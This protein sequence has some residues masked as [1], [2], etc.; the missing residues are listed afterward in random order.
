MLLKLLVIFHTLGATIW[1]G[2][3]LILAITIVPQALKNR[4]LEP[5]R[6]FEEH[7][8]NLGLLALLVQVLSTIKNKL[9][10]QQALEEE[11]REKQRLL[12]KLRVLGLEP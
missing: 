10:Y 4:E 2:G 5:I 12:E 6:Q 9:E 7:F 1:T 3:H 11:R 8:E